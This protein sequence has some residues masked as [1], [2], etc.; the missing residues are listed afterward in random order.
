MRETVLE[1]QIL[2]SYGIYTKLMFIK[3]E[4]REKKVWKKD[5]KNS[6]TVE[7]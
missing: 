5:T 7:K 1:T 4:F 2:Y 6:G 3:P